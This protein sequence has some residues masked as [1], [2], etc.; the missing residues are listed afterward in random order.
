MILFFICI[1]QQPD[2][3]GV[4]AHFQGI[5]DAVAFMSR[6]AN[7]TKEDCFVKPIV[8]VGH[9][10]ARTASAAIHK[11]SRIRMGDDPTRPDRTTTS[12]QV[13]Q[14]LSAFVDRQSTLPQMRP[15]PS[16]SIQA[17]T[18]PRTH[19]D[20]DGAGNITGYPSGAQDAHNNMGQGQ[21]E[22]M[23]YVHLDQPNIP[24]VPEGWNYD[25]G[26][27]GPIDPLYELPRTF[28]WNW[29]DLSSELLRDFD[30]DFHSS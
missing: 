20:D 7:N 30:F 21:N 18:E 5:H 15:A 27:F 28:L 25:E 12:S 23:P 1:L 2:L 29:H 10:L 3:A 8:T 13:N 17:P 4:D 14:R 22:S 19:D 16:P 6:L 9:E 26:I 11:G 24:G